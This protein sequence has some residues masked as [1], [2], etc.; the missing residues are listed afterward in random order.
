M[1]NHTVLLVENNIGER[2]FF[3]DVL[4]GIGCGVVVAENGPDALSL[5]KEKI[6]DL[7][8]AD[9]HM[10]RMD[11]LALLREVAVRSPEIPVILVSANSTVEMS[12]EAMRLGAF[13]FVVKPFSRETIHEVVR[14]VFEKKANDMVCAQ[15]PPKQDRHKLVTRSMSNLLGLAQ[16]VA[17]SKASV[18]IQGESGTGKELFARFIHDQSQRRLKPFVAIN[19]AALPDGLLE[20][21]LF[22]HEKGAFTGAIS[23]KLGKFELAQ[24][25]T[26]LLDEI[27]EMALQLQAKLL[28][29][30]QE[31]EIDRVGGVCPI[32]LDVRIVATTNRDVETAIKEKSFR[33]DLYYRLNVIPIRIP[34]LRERIEDIPLLAEYFIQ[35]YNRIDGRNVKGLTED[36]LYRFKNML[37]PGNV[38]EL[39]NIIERSVLLCKGEVITEEDIFFVN[40]SANLNDETAQNAPYA[41]LGSLRD[42]EKQMIYQALSHTNGNRTSA[43]KILG[44]NVR[45]LRNKLSEYQEHM[46]ALM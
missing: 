33:E 44:I 13:D 37:W 4:A 24:G 46:E 27:T 25:G 9:L 36:A 3:Y 10:P 38:R 15:E 26:I 34:P 5:L 16:R 8:F 41:P 32:Q 35:K 21:E 30:L 45:T 40:P 7:V 29:V 2:E 39:E 28:R 22:G 43:A 11:G 23:R 6:I 42:V 12:V 1:N 20:S 19:C 31:G 14:R 17:N 18:L